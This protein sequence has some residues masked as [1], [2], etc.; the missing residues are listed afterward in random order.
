MRRREVEHGLERP[1][2]VRTFNVAGLSGAT[3]VRLREVGGKAGAEFAGSPE[4]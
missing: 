4:L 3:R 1:G 2:L